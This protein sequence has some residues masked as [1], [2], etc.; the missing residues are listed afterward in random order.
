MS[1]TPF[2][3]L[4]RKSNIHICAGSNLALRTH[5]CNLFP[6]NPH[7]DHPIQ[8]S[9]SAMATG[10]DVLLEHLLFQVA[11]SGDIGTSIFLFCRVARF[12][13]VRSLLL[14]ETEMIYSTLMHGKFMSCFFDEQRH[15]LIT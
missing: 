1:S 13:V 4:T 15:V 2:P 6:S 9:C 12:C 11:L 8:K 3:T 7:P 10:S 14:V 5:I